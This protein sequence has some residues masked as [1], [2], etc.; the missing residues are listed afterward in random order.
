MGVAGEPGPGILSGAQGPSAKAP[1]PPSSTVVAWL[2]Y[3][4]CW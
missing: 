1:G 4:R 2:A 3:K